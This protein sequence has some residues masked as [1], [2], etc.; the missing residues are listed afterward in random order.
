MIVVVVKAT[1]EDETR[2]ALIPETCARLKK[3]GLDL[4][5][6]TGAGAAAGFA[7]GEYETAG[8]RIAPN[9]AAAFGEADAVVM[10]GSP[11]PEEIIQIKSGTLLFCVLN[12]LS[13]H[14]A[15]GQ[16]AS[17]GR[18]HRDSHQ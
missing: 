8:A 3:S 12:P 16:L 4:L 1:A 2:V 7:D 17:I 14:D 5:V 6:E 18:S 10:V 13:Q 11:S 15:V 9:A